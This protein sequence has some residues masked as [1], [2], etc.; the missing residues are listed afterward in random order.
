MVTPIRRQDATVTCERQLLASAHVPSH[1]ALISGQATGVVSLQS[2][3]FE[4]SVST[5]RYTFFFSRKR[6]AIVARDD[7]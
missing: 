1:L 6:S 7:E 5:S 2:S 3:A 4:E